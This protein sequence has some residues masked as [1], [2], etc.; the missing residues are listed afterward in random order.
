[1][2]VTPEHWYCHHRNGEIRQHWRAL[3]PERLEPVAA[4]LLREVSTVAVDDGRGVT[5]ALP[6]LTDAVG[7]AGEAVHPWVAYG[8]RGPARG[9]PAVVNALRVPG[10]RDR[11]DTDR[12]GADLGRLVRAAR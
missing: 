10:A 4:R 5:A 11:L 2:G 1:M 7:E 6:R 9:G 8:T 12:L 3:P